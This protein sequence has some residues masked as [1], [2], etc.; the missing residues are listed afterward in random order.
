M[1]YQ[2]L[3]HCVINSVLIKVLQHSMSFSQILFTQLILFLS[4]SFPQRQET[5]FFFN[6]L[7]NIEYLLHITFI[8]SAGTVNCFVLL[9]MFSN[10]LSS[11]FSTFLLCSLA[12]AQV[13][14][15]TVGPLTPLSAKSTI[16]NILD[17]GGVAD[18][19]T[20]IG[21][22]IKSAFTSCAINGGAT[23]YIP[24]G[25]YSRKS[26]IKIIFLSILIT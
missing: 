26:P 8:R 6:T 13:D 21:P 20:D 24:P 16:C 2:R 22:A 4:I 7:W 25:S 23:L 11:V 10:L 17:Y 1:A 3:L 19:S 12:Q 9:P 5:P 14:L 18:N 15:D